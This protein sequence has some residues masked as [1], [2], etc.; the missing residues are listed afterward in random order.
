MGCSAVDRGPEDKKESNN[1][2]IPSMA[3]MMIEEN[4]HEVSLYSTEYIQ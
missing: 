2:S 3:R 4:F 1:T